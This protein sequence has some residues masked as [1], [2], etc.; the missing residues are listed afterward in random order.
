MLKYVFMIA[1]KMQK[2]AAKA[3]ENFPYIA[4]GYGLVD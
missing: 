3:V 4:N 1:L 2:T